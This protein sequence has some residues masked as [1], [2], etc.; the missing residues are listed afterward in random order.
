LEG[1]ALEYG[2]YCDVL[3]SLDSDFAMKEIRVTGGGECSTTW[4]IIKAGVLG[5]PVVQMAR[6][7]GA[8]AGAALLAGHGVGLFDDLDRAAQKW[9][10][11]GPA[12]R[13]KR[14]EIALCKRRLERY[15]KLLDILNTVNFL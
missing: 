5:C 7:E 14:G 13:P 3:R 11:R 4:N 1:V 6:S 10:R 15:R 9:S 8:P 2:I 12:H